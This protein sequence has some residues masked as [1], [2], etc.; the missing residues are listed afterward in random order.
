M[1]KQKTLKKAFTLNGIGLHTGMDIKLSFLPAPENHGLVIK[2]IDLKGQP[3]IPA[4]A[5]FV[6]R[7]NRGTV[8]SCEDAQISTIEHAMAALFASEI[9]NCLMEVNAPEFPILDG[10]A[11]PFIEQIQKAGIQEQKAD[12]DY[13]TVKKKIEYADPTG[14]SSIILLPDESFSIQ[15][16]IGFPSVILNNQ[17]AVLDKLSDFGAEIA[18][19]R[20]FVFVRELE[21]LLAM[22]LIK[23]G[24]LENALVIYDEMTSQE[25]FDRIADLVGHAHVSVDQLGYLSPLQF[26]NEPARHKLLDVLGDLALI[27]KPIKGKVI[28]TCPGHTINTALAKL[29]RKEIKRQEVSIPVYDPNKEPVFDINQIKTMLP[30]RWPFLMVDKILEMTDSVVI[31]LKNVTGNEAFFNGHFPDEPVMPGVLLVEAMAQTGGL[32]V[33][34]HVDNPKLYS[35]YFIKIDNVKFRRKV[36]PGDTILFRL[37]LLAPIRRNLVSMKGYAFVGDKIAVEAELMA[38]V[39]KNKETA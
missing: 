23:G 3:L 21:Q 35:T 29:I 15:T 39:I 7:T 36:V 19:C 34:G 33:L 27:G 26:N 22:N 31:G 9:D 5:E 2:R 37:E 38:Q 16:L 25:E 11:K 8:L 1:P 24:D 10:S 12:K 6:T 13:F 28:A 30:H 32:L 17:F 20:T 18:S 14:Q 4:L